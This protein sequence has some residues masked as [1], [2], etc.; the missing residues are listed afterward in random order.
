MLTLK[1]IS[2]FVFTMLFVL[3]GHA[4]FLQL[5]RAATGNVMMIRGEE[6]SSFTI[7]GATVL[8]RES[9]N[10]LSVG[11]SVPDSIFYPGK[12]VDS[13]YKMN[14]V[15]NNIDFDG[16]LK[17]I[18]S[19]KVF[20]TRGLLSFNNMTK[21]VE[22][23]YTPMPSGTDDQGGFRLFVT[24]QFIPS[25]FNLPSLENTGCMILINNAPVNR[26]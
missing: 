15:A 10:Q 18:T 17:N 2:F 7:N 5:Y 26:I 1:S 23:Q 13:V 14:A 20:S 24:I 6:R 9:N 3:R 16:I 12:V 11:L 19:S 8:L 22:I 4:Q 25:D 21:P